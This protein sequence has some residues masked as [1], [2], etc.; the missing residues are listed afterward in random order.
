MVPG[1]DGNSVVCEADKANVRTVRQT[2]QVGRN[3]TSYHEVD[4]LA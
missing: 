2:L 4:C 3:G 1:I